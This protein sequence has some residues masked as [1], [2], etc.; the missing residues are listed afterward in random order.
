MKSEENFIKLI[1]DILTENQYKVRKID[2]ID[3]II[4]TDLEDVKSSIFVEVKFTSHSTMGYYNI[5][6]IANSVSNRF[7]IYANSFT[8]PIPFKGVI[9]VSAIVDDE[10]IKEVDKKYKI[11]VL[12][13]RSLYDFTAIRPLHRKQLERYLFE[14]VLDYSIPRIRYPLLY[15]ELKPSNTFTAQIQ[16]FNAKSTKPDKK[17]GEVLCEG[18]QLIKP[19]FDEFKKYENHV[20]EILKYLFENDLVDW[21]PQTKTDSG[22][23]IFDLIV[24]VTNKSYFWSELTSDFHSKYVVFEFKNYSK[25]LSPG[26]I[27][28]TERY[29]YKQALRNVG[30]IICRKNPGINAIIAAKGVLKESGKL[31]LFFTDLDLC[32]MLH[33][34]DRNEELDSY[35]FAKLN[36]FLITIDRN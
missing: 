29:L 9:I 7:D 3:L 21:S 18:L 4:E 28:S 12:D 23:N 16:A 20:I 34:K 10:G 30:I 14:N 15:E 22:L 17:K 24:R 32:N 26:Q 33:A 36:D 6:E 25:S 11:K 19:G 13:V 31:L 8:N 35:L 27:Y 2:H 5:L 1:I